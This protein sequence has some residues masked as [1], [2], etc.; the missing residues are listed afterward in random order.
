MNRTSVD[1]Q[2][3]A[4]RREVAFDVPYERFTG[5]LESLL[6]RMKVGSPNTIT[7]TTAAPNMLREELAASVGQS[8]FALFQMI[9]HGVLLT[10]LGGLQTIPAAYVFGNAL[11]AVDK[12][13][14]R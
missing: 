5:A 13:K 11:F 9:D 4:P 3:T 2:Y 7:A 14:H 1:L 6:G 12:G 10:A 8:D